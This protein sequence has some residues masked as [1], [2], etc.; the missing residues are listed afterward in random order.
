MLRKNLSGLITFL[1]GFALVFALV[2]C[3]GDVDN[4]S[5]S[6]APDISDDGGPTSG[7]GLPGPAEQTGQ[8]SGWPSAKLSPYSHG[9]WNQPAGLS[10]ISW[11]ERHI[12]GR[13]IYFLEITF[14]SATETT[15]NSIT[16]YL[17]SWAS[18]TN[19][20]QDDPNNFEVTYVKV[21]DSVNYSVIVKCDVSTGGYINVGR[22]SGVSELQ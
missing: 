6:L 2:G 9:G 14:S 4:S 3:G 21:V 12:G 19:W 15:R 18:E 11:V 20:I 17:E 16:D 13:D 5:P 1:V 7:S 22:V 10:G 8:G